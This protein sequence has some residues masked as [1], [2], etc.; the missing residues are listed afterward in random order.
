VPFDGSRHRIKASIDTW[1][2][3]QTAATTSTPA[4]TQAVFTHNTP[5]HLKQHNASAKIEEIIEAHILQVWDTVTSNQ[6]QDKE[7]FSQD[8]LKVFAAERKKHL[9]KASELS[10]PHPKTPVP[11]LVLVAQAPATNPNYL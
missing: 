5:L 3:S 11:A 10:T 6:D 9:D 7:D 2:T 4:Q 1:L 8:I